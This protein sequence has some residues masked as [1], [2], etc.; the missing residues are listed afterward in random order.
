MKLN[1]K[2]C[3]NEVK[4]LNFQE[5]FKLEIW[6]MVNQDLKLVAIRKLVDEFKLSHKEAKTIV[7][8]INKEFGK[9]HR[10][11]FNNLPEEN[12]ECPKCRSFNY[13]LKLVTTKK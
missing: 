6:R 11:N 4:K 2:R 5:E 1:C 7:I 12:M 8:H 10:C 9:C 13:N 3:G